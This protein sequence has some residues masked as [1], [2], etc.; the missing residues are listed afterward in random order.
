MLMVRDSQLWLL[1]FIIT[2]YNWH[3][4]VYVIHR[5]YE[6]SSR[7]KFLMFLHHVLIVTNLMVGY[8]FT[9]PTNIMIHLLLSVGVILCWL[10]HKGCIVSIEQSKMIDYSE[11]DRKVLHPQDFNLI[12]LLILP[13]IILD[14]YKIFLNK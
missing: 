2:A 1:I 3:T 7:V 5:K 11:S 8:F 6:L 9:E 13:G 14:V 4:D 10:M 12:L